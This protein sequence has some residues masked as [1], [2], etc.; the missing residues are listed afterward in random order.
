MSMEKKIPKDFY[1]K[2]YLFHNHDLVNVGID[3]KEDAEFHYLQHGVSENRKY[4][5]APLCTKS[6]NKL[7]D[8]D[9][10]FKIFKNSLEAIVLLVTGNETTNGLYDRFCHELEKH[11]DTTDINFVLITKSS[12]CEYIDINFFKKF[13]NNVTLISLDIPTKDDKYYYEDQNKTYNTISDYGYYAGPNYTFYESF[14]YLKRYNTCLFLE[15]DCY[16]GNNW[17][18]RL[19]N[20]VKYSGDFWICGSIFDGVLDYQ[21]T[22]FNTRVDIINT[23]IN[24]GTALYATGNEDFVKFLEISE[25]YLKAYVKEVNAKVP[26]DH[27]IRESLDISFRLF[28]KQNSTIA[29]F[30]NRKYLVNNLI[31]NYSNPESKNIEISEI[32]KMYD[33][34]V[35]HKK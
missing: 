4:S 5:A 9:I 27:F 17:I 19:K 11:T 26:Y 32:E 33:F 18:D 24:G 10:S 34:A 28:M 2:Q 35:L 16:F 21:H 25:E 29:R 14:R 30:I 7:I 6:I 13:F 31:L 15:C 1:W 12:M 22:T 3:N 8:L 23:H 20:F